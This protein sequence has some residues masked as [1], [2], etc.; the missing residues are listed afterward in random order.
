MRRAF[1]TIPLLFCT[2]GAT[3][4]GADPVRITNGVLSVDSGDP[5]HFVFE[6][7]GFRATGFD[8]FSDENP[9]SRCLPCAP[10][11]LVSM[12]ASFGPDLGQGFFGGDG[13][14][15]SGEPV[16]WEGFLQFD[17][18]VSA[19]GLEGITLSTPFTFVGELAAFADASRLGTPLF[20]E[21]LIGSGR[22][23]FLAVA[24][25]DDQPGGLVTES[26]AYV[27][28]PTAPIPEPTTMLLVGAGLAGVARRATRRRSP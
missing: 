6:A 19:G 14:G 5:L 11:E 16:F 18:G 28:E 3:D 1:L 17:T 26:M 27:F 15:D 4:A 2:L 7:E 12:D 13:G 21:S 22:L 25:E 23:F 10:G 8:F 20:R 24:D 9:G